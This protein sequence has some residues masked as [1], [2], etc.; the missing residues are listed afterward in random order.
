MIGEQKKI[1]PLVNRII[2]KQVASTLFAACKL[3]ESNMKTGV[4]SEFF[5]NDSIER[6]LE[7]A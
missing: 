3:F 7:E 5:T 6:K 2:L 1:I 4:L